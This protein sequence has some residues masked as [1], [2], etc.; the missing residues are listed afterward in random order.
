MNHPLCSLLKPRL[1]IFVRVLLTLQGYLKTKFGLLQHSV[2][3]PRQ[4]PYSFIN[5]TTYA[6]HH[7]WHIY[8]PPKQIP[9]I[10]TNTAL[11][12][13]V[14]FN[15]LLLVQRLLRPDLLN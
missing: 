15:N 14:T 13:S 2:E 4:L 6:G 3:D 11:L 7:S 9:C 1:K 10:S 12:Y 8:S 5:S